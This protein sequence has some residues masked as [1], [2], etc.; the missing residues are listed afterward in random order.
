MQ[1]RVGFVCAIAFAL[2][3]RLSAA[4]QQ[5]AAA[6]ATEAAMLQIARD[7]ATNALAAQ[8]MKGA[9]AAYERVVTLLGAPDSFLMH[10]LAH[11]ALTSLETSKDPEVRRLTCQTLAPES[12]EACADSRPTSDAVRA[13]MLDRQQSLGAVDHLRD[14]SDATVGP[15]ITLLENSTYL[16]V[17]FS[18]A[19]QLGETHSQKA[20]DALRAWI[21]NKPDGPARRAAVISM[22]LLGDTDSLAHVREMLPRL[23]GEDQLAAGRALAAAGDAAGEA[24]IRDAFNGESDSVRLQAAVQMASFAAPQ[25]RETLSAGLSAPNQWVRAS[26][27]QAYSDLAWEPTRELRALL[28]DGNEWVRLRAAQAMHAWARSH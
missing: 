24:V 21:I 5:A 22:A 13:G 12:R 16:E 9:L 1:F 10:E 27:A 6:P 23:S 11:T 26:A 15:L 7:D 28:L 18:A 4:P 17:Q 2:S 20:L 14:G 25:A 3:V 8:N 19:A